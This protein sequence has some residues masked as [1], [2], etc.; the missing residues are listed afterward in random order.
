MEIT[1]KSTNKKSMKIAFIRMSLIAA[2]GAAPLLV[3]AAGVSPSDTTPAAN[4]YNSQPDVRTTADTAGA[5]PST[6]M[7]HKHV[8]HATPKRVNEADPVTSPVTNGDSPLMNA[9]GINGGP[10]R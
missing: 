6:T 4:S 1:M 10:A 3:S 2:V 8:K 7:H 9:P 5:T